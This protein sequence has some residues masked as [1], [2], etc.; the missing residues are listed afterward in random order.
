MKL[1]TASLFHWLLIVLLEVNAAVGDDWI[2]SGYLPD[3]RFYINVNATAA[4]GLTDL[5]LFSLEPPSLSG[6]CLHQ[7][8]HWPIAQQAVAFSQERTSNS[9]KLWLTV[10]GAGRSMGFRQ[11]FGENEGKAFMEKLIVFARRHRLTGI[12]FD[13]ELPFSQQE[14]YQ[15]MSF[16]Q[17]ACIELHKAGLLVSVALHPKQTITKTLAVLLDRVHLMAYDFPGLPYHS[18][19]PRVKQAVQFLLKSGLSANKIVLGI[20][21]YGRHPTN[22]NLVK[23]YA[24]LVDELDSKITENTNSIH[25][26]KF[27]S[28]RVIHQKVEYAIEQ[29]LAGVFVWELG[30]DK[31]VPLAPRGIVLE[32]IHQRLD[33]N[34]ESQTFDEL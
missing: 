19:L 29:G 34:K 27:D 8:N 6:C 3:Y 26:I 15:Y 9:L 23:T 5:I 14:Y 17:F 4:I 30:Q 13:C 21:A 31:V 11:L 24:E 1:K 10:G 12:D 7:D 33:R 20:P 22:P 25:G 16:L 28:P 18:D 32:S 2:V